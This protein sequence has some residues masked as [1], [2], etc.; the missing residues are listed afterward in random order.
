MGD[1]DA[2]TVDALGNTLEAIEIV[3]RTGGVGFRLTFH[4]R[5]RHGTPVVETSARSFQTLIDAKEYAR[6]EFG[7]FEFS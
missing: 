6:S 1:I 4:M 7:A 2:A 5:S 3:E